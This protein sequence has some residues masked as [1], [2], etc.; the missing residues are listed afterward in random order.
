M[1]REMEDEEEGRDGGREGRE[2]EREEEREGGREGERE[3][4]G[5]HAGPVVSS[6]AGITAMFGQIRTDSSYTQSESCLISSETGEMLGL[7]PE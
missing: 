2:R 7:C 5:M 3:G 1:Y 4:G 6:T